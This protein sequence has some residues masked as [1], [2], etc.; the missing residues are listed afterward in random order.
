MN[1]EDLTLSLLNELENANNDPRIYQVG[2]N[3]AKALVD[4]GG[5]KLLLEVAA[6]KDKADRDVI[7]L[8]L[9]HWLK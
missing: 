2:Y 7:L 8:D 3:M 6:V 5:K 1:R 9:L 4:L